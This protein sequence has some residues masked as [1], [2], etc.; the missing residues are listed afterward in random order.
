MGEKLDSVVNTIEPYT[1]TKKDVEVGVSVI[2]F[3]Q[4]ND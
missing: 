3:S 4:A 2:Q 1:L